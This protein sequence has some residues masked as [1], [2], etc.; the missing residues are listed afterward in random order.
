MRKFRDICIP[1]IF[2]GDA[3]VAVAKALKASRESGAGP[4]VLAA[5]KERSRDR[6]ARRYSKY[7]EAAREK[8]K[9]G[10]DDIDFDAIPE[11]S[12]RENGAYV[13]AWIW[14]NTDE[15]NNQID[16]YIVPYSDKCDLLI[17]PM[18]DKK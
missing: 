18:P 13:Q 16:K 1:L 5:A 2:R 15:V 10:S 11:V 6:R 9:T 12:E 14:V 17:T 7:I 3:A 4:R 8:A